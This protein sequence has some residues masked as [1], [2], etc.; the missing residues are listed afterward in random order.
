MRTKREIMRRIDFFSL[1]YRR[2][3]YLL[4]LFRKMVAST[5]ASMAAEVN[6]VNRSVI[7]FVQV[8]CIS[9]FCLGAVGLALNIYVF[10]RRRF[11]S[12]SC[13]YYFLASTLAGCC[14]I[15]GVVPLRLLQTVYYIDIFVYSFSACQI[16]SY[17]LNCFR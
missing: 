5:N 16:L 7:I 9:V 10:T 6:N 14:I 2:H 13:T 1:F 17:L 11:L 3:N 8:W 12:N 4:L 15:Y